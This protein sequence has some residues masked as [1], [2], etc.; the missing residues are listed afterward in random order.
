MVDIIHKVINIGST[1]TR[2]SMWF[3]KCEVLGLARGRAK[4]SVQV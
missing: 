1:T 3:S 4:R 2:R